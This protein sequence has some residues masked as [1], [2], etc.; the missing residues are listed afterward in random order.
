MKGQW[1][2]VV[3]LTCRAF[4]SSTTS[5]AAC[6]LMCAIIEADLLE[7]TVFT[8]VVSSILSSANLNGPSAISDASLH[9]WALI[10]ERSNQT[11]IGSAQNV[12]KQI[13]S[14]LREVWTI[15]MSSQTPMGNF[16]LYSRSELM[17]ILQARSRTVYKP[18]KL[19][20][21]P[22]LWICFTSFW[23]APTGLSKKPIPS[24]QYP[25]GLSAGCGGTCMRTGGFWT[26]FL[27]LE[28]SL[29]LLIHGVERHHGY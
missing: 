10:A 2:R 29:I 15:G 9:L 5:R 19:R 14:W 24:M 17:R 8:E 21:S 25:Q 20:C 23:H 22:A 7:Y 6:K 3:D 16:I 13:C 26:I 4:S 12:S 18:R 28:V 1:P 11:C 27:P